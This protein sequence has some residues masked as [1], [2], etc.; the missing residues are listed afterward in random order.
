MLHMCSVQMLCLLFVWPQSLILLS[1]RITGLVCKTGSVH[2][3]VRT[4][5]S[6]FKCRQKRFGVSVMCLP[7]G[8]QLFLKAVF[9]A[10]SSTRWSWKKKKN[11][12]NVSTFVK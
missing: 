6:Y 8:P 10:D 3:S 9:F 4:C 1:V 2:F 5:K 11:K 7:R 12:C